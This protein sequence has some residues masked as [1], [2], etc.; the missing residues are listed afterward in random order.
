MSIHSYRA[1]VDGMRAIAVLSVVGFHAFP[2]AVPGGFVG[3]DVFFVIS[4]FLITSIISERI[5]CGRF[6]VIEFY[7]RRARRILP[8]LI[9]TLIASAVLGWIILFPDEFAALQ[10]HIVGAALFGSNV[11]VWRESGYFDAAAELKPLLH[12]WSLGVEE[13]FYI[14][15]PAVLLLAYRFTRRVPLVLGAAMLASFAANILIVSTHGAAAFYLLPTRAWELLAGALLVYVP[16]GR[17]LFLP[18]AGLA[19]IAAGVALIRP[20]MAFPG[21]LAVLPVA[22]AACIIAGPS[23]RRLAHPALVFVGLIS[24]PLYMFHWPLLAYL[25]ILGVDDVL[26]R[27]IAVL[28]SFG[29]AWAFFVLIERP[30]RKGQIAIGLGAALATATAVLIS[31]P[32][33]PALDEQV[34]LVRG[35]RKDAE[36]VSWA[37]EE[38]GPLGY[39]K[40]GRSSDVLVVGDSHAQA[41]Y[42]GLVAKLGAS[43]TRV[44]LLAASGCPPALDLNVYKVGKAGDKLRCPAFWRRVVSYAER[45]RPGLIVLVGRGPL[46]LDEPYVVE[47]GSETGA[48]AF[49]AATFD[50]VSK[51]APVSRLAYVLEGPEFRRMAIDCLRRLATGCPHILS[52]EEARRPM[53]KYREII[54]G[55][56]AEVPLTVI[57]SFPTF[58]RN[59]AC[60]QFDGDRVLYADRH[61]LTP[62]GGLRVVE[63]SGMGDL[64]TTISAGDTASIKRPSDFKI[65][66]P[67]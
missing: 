49:T 14:V 24:Y 25:N 22:G 17:L 16:R 42:D 31:I 3:V 56:A 28:L 41:I 29:L 11:V 47:R 53:A 15:F 58:C 10:K 54:A 13:Q 62:A 48:A 26:P 35:S 4:G 33:P 61:H 37:R 38:I 65:R 43:S 1:D 2:S 9:A 46:Y 52:E 23:T 5:D 67:R 32:M 36:C 44:T 34:Q 51:L 40:G 12:L 57:D 45:D 7:A 66:Q 50:L 8:A 64:V 30:I 59:G 6:S 20:D 19:L 39:C 27:L 18:A 55:I 63:Q 21:W 60:S